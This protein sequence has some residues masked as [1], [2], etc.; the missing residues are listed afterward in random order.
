MIKDIIMR[1]QQ[2]IGRGSKLTLC[3]SLHGCPKPP[4]CFWMGS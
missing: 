4:Q 1:K 3:V 2:G